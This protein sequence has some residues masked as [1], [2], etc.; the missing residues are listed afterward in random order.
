LDK[1]AASIIDQ[2]F[3]IDKDFAINLLRRPAVAFYNINPLQLALKANC[4]AF[5]ASR[6]VQRHLDNEW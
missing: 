5:L 3:D 4:R 2:C 6:C 1:Y